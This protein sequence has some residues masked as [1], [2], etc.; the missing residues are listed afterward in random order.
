[1]HFSEST[2]AGIHT[3]NRTNKSIELELQ[4]EEILEP[5]LEKRGRHV[6]QPIE[7]FLFEY[8]SFSPNK[9][10]TWNPGFNLQ[11]AVSWSPSDLKYIFDRDTDTWKLT[12]SDFPE[13]RLKML[14]WVIQLQEAMMSR[15]PAF[16]CHGLHEWAMVYKIDEVRH[17]QL[18]LRLSPEE[19]ARTVDSLPIRCSH[20][21]A[22]RFFTPAAEPKNNLNPTYESRIQLEQG[23]CIHANMDLYKWAYK[24]HPWLGSELIWEAFLLAREIRYFDMQASPYDLS[25][26]GLNPICIEL[27]E[28]RQEYTQKQQFFANKARIVREK[29][30]FELK[31]MESW[32]TQDSI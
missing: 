25:A 20:Y 4:V 32:A 31:K 10:R 6:R 26:F 16:G 24:F 29:L 28:G 14:R 9:L 27:P 19:I 23:G 1:M 13:K 5:F 8:Y 18:P 3:H 17:Q 21:D 7:D 22:F 11:P 30:I 2:I 12:P 15:P